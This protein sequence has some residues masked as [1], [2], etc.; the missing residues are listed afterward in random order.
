VLLAIGAVPV[1]EV[2]LVI[3]LTGTKSDAIGWTPVGAVAML[4][5][6]VVVVAGAVVTGAVVVGLVAIGSVKMT[7]AG[8]G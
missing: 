3:L 4:V 2:E 6:V 7:P 1:V 5:V 8:A